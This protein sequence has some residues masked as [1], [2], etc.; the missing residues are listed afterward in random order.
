MAKR[1]QLYIIHIVLYIKVVKL[2]IYNA[3]K[4]PDFL[5]YCTDLHILLNTKY[6]GSF[7]QC[8]GTPGKSLDIQCSKETK[9]KC[10]SF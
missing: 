4:L 8:T 6:V 5:F 2:G 7:R 10:G 1:D 3:N 9:G